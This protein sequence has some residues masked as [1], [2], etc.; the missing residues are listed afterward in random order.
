MK[1][2]AW[3][4]R[5][6]FLRSIGVKVNESKETKKDVRFPDNINELES[7]VDEMVKDGILS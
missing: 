3:L 4:T 1:F 7:Q 6:R 5:L 2:P